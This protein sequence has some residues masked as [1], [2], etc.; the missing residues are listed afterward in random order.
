[1][2]NKFEIQEDKDTFTFSKCDFLIGVYCIV[3]VFGVGL[4]LTGVMVNDIHNKIQCESV[5]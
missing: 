2:K 4:F 3:I 5:E 1:M